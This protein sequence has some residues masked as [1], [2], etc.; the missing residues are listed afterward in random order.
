[1]R[2]KSKLTGE[3]LKQTLWETLQAVKSKK[4][5]PKLANAIATQSREIMRVV[6]TEISLAELTGE[7]PQTLKLATGAKRNEMPKM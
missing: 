7:K 6:R 4:I 1:M 5:D 3:N 2:N